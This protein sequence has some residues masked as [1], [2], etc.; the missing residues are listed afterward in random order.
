MAPWGSAEEVP[1]SATLN[2]GGV[3]QVNSLSCASAGN[4]SANGFYVTSSDS[5][6]AFVVKE[7]NGTWGTAKEVPGTATFN[8]GGNAA[9]QSMSCASAGNCSAG[10][11]YQSS[12]GQ[13]AFVVSETNGSWAKAKEV[14]GTAAL[15]AGGD[16]EVLSVSCAAAGQLRRRRFVRRP[17]GGQRVPGARRQRDNE[18]LRPST[19]A[20]GVSSTVSVSQPRKG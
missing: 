5:H 19:E 2:T 16:G 13:Q 17:A 7:T 15:N 9:V 18:S 8:T 10:A 20:A 3:A 11:G 1:R 6:E 4:C 14:P 12:S